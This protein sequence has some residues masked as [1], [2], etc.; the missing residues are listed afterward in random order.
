MKIEVIQIFQWPLKSR[1]R[2]LR[3]FVYLLRVLYRL[4]A[5][6]LRAYTRF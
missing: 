3:V 6:G 1:N 4:I 5:I 2:R